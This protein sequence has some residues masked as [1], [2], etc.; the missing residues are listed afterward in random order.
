MRD[1][2]KIMTEGDGADS[3]Y[4][5][6]GYAED[7]VQIVALALQGLSPQEAVNAASRAS[8]VLEI[9]AVILDRAGEGA[10]ILERDRRAAMKAGVAA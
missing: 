7:I 9:A 5:L 1:F 8:A 4:Q 10:F 6:T 3:V 2:A